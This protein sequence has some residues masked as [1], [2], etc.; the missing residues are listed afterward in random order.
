MS[1]KQ[2][3][4]LVEGFHLGAQVFQVNDSNLL[5]QSRYAGLQFCGFDKTARGIDHAYASGFTGSRDA[6]SSCRKIKHGRNPAVELKR[7]KSNQRAYH[8]WQQQTDDLARLTVPREKVA[9]NKSAA[10]ELIVGNAVALYIL[11]DHAAPAVNTA[12]FQKRT[13][14]GLVMVIGNKHHFGHDVGQDVGSLNAP[15]AAAKARRQIDAPRRQQRQGDA[16]KPAYSHETTESGKRR[17]LGA[18][19]AY[20]KHLSLR[21]V[22]H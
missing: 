17:V 16:R 11:G 4:Q 14:Q 2:A 5:A 8:V 10:D 22:R 1:V 6:L 21:F 3:H 12:R 13:K 7:H 15:G 19:N 9:E 20:R 18:I